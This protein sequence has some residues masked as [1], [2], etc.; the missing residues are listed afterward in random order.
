LSLVVAGGV[1]AAVGGPALIELLRDL[2][3]YP[4]FSL[5]YASII[6]LAALSLSIAAFLP[7]YS[8]MPAMIKPNGTPAKEHALSI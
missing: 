7:S 5:C 6:G 4:L 1:V 3:G 8:E 2:R